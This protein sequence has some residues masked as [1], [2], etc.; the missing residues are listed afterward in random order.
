MTSYNLAQAVESLGGFD[1]FGLYEKFG[2]MIE[3]A[4]AQVT[5]AA[6]E[7]QTVNTVSQPSA[8]EVVG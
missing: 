6:L 7:Q 4:D 5:Q 2:A 1:Q 3:Q 8:V